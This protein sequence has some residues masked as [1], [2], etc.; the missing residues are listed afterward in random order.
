M[1]IL[2]CRNTRTRYRL[3]SVSVSLAVALGA[4]A[5][6]GKAEAATGAVLVG[7]SGDRAG[8]E[9]QIGAALYGYEFGALTDLS[10]H[11]EVVTNI[12]AVQRT[13]TRMVKLK[14]RAV[15]DGRYDSALAR[16][17]RAVKAYPAKVHL[18][19]AHEPDGGPKKAH[20]TAADFKAAWRHVHD[21]F[22]AHGTTNVIWNL[23]MVAGAYSAGPASR[24]YIGKWTPGDAY[25]DEY[26]DDA[27]NWVGCIRRS[28]QWAWRELS[29]S[30]SGLVAYARAHHKKATLPEW[31]SQ[32]DPND[33]NRRA[34]WL[35]RAHTWLAANADVFAGVWYFNHHATRGG[36][37]HFGITTPA[38]VRAVKG[39]VRDPRF[40]T[41]HR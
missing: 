5:A 6:P 2:L 14:W 7:A 35:Q 30:A 28:D 1:P 10:P 8:L 20:G 23:V 38:E 31:G 26:G 41:P 29:Q 33:R 24:H 3:C 32:P 4:S 17:A 40:T 12:E 22:A 27:Y 18:S 25:V 37:C 11:V 19:F 36:A 15:A 34:V 13:S 39:L 21:Y 16:W 9:Q